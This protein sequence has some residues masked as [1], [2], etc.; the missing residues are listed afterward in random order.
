MTKVR[1]RFAPSPTG[2]LHIGGARTALY[3][4][5]YAKKRGGQFVLRIEDTDEER[6]KKEYEESQIEDLK[7][8]GLQWDEGPYRQS[9]RLE[10][11]QKFA[12][13]LLEKDLAYYAFDSEED[14][15]EMKERAKREKRPPHYDG[16][17]K[18]MSYEEA[19]AK[20]MAGE[21]GVIR[22]RAPRKSYVL[23]DAVRGRVVFPTGMVGDF[24]IMR[25]NGRPVYNFC[26]VVDD[27]QM[28]ITH[29]VRAEEHLPNTLRQLMLY[30]ALDPLTAIPP[31]TFAHVSLLLGEDRQK[32][33]KRHGATS[34][35]VFREQSYSPEAMINYLSLLGWSHPQEKDIFDREELIDVFTLDRLSKSPALFD[36]TKFKYVNGQHL[37]KLPLETLV[38]LTAREMPPDSEFHRQDDQ[39]KRSFVNLFKN[40]VEFISKMPGHLSVVFGTGTE[41]RSDSDEYRKFNSLESTGRIREYLKGRL[42]ELHGEGKGFID[43]SIWKTWVAHIK[44]EL[45]ITGKPLFMGMRVALMGQEKGPELSLVVPLVPVKVLLARVVSAS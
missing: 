45:G 30:E 41:E 25:S 14:L 35:S 28:G 4:Y 22:L 26:C 7:W 9:E 38:T 20:R 17:Y 12:Q 44:S 1:T 2:F 16:P 23:K 40:Q 10:I 18:N 32:L 15:R 21:K 19:V 36:L 3:S 27:W 43:Q 11:Y 34:V 39:W 29:V 13:E 42:E 5:L 6:S 33:S 31:P 8:L 24:V 37:M